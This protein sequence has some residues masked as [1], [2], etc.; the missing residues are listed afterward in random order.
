QPRHITIDTIEHQ[1]AFPA[2]TNHGDGLRANE[3]R[4]R[5]SNLPSR[6][7]S[8]SALSA[9]GN[10]LGRTPDPHRCNIIGLRPPTNR[11]AA[12]PVQMGFAGGWRGSWRPES[13]WLGVSARLAS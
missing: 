8:G 5:A 12:H 1:G 11:V 13:P 3:R 4:K 10:R 2:R 7:G 9:T 6:H